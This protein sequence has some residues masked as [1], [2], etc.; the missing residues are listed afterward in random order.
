M[1]PRNR[2][3]DGFYAEEKMLQYSELRPSARFPGILQ[4]C[5]SFDDQGLS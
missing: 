2:H 3:K 1:S 4:L 5:V